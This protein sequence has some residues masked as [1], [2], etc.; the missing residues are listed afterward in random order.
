MLRQRAHRT[1]RTDMMNDPSTFPASVSLGILAWNE[2]AGLEAVLERLFAQTLFEH[3]AARRESCEIV[4]VPN[5]CTDNTAAVAREVFAR[6]KADHLHASAFE[7]RVVEIPLPGKN[8]AWNRFVHEFAVPGARFIGFMDADIHLHHPD[9]LLNLVRTLER[10]PDAWVA[11]DRQVK[12]L[13]FKARKTLRDRI[14]LATSDMTDTIEG[15]LTGQLYL[16][17][18]PIA[19]RLYLPH[20]LGSL[21]DGFFKAILCTDFLT[22]PSNPRRILTA[23]DASHIFEAYRRVR[24]VLKNQKRQMIGQTTVHVL[25]EYLQQQPPE[26][27]LHLAD[28]LRELDRRDPDWLRRLL[29]Q[30]LRRTHA[31]W[32]LF[33]NLLTFRF[34]R[35]A[36]MRGVQRVTHFPAAF[37]G[38]LVT[39]WA[40]AQAYRFLRRGQ[41]HYWPQARRKT[42][43]HPLHA[44]A[45]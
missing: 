34:Q 18:A 25:L 8:N 33:P 45:K 1:P 37:A 14:S 12:E 3:L 13:V 9:T 32:R 29:D 7:G 31:F 21:E 41:T 43:V 36:R 19:R 5:G 26:D 30:H 20:A 38:F 44:V 17:R 10:E 22:R 4:C 11:T 35:L 40:S 15:R 28:T 39:L 27:R 23:P 2:A 16:M 24:D 42:A 6:I